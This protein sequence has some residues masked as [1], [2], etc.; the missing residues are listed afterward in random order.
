MKFNIPAGYV[1]ITKKDGTTIVCREEQAM[2]LLSNIPAEQ[3]KPAFEDSA[4]LRKALKNIEATDAVDFT[5][6]AL[7]NRPFLHVVISSYN[8]IL[9]EKYHVADPRA[10]TTEL[11]SKGVLYSRPAK[12]GALISLKP[13]TKPE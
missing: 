9:R 7:S 4:V 8:E 6:K 12:K 10:F 11:V 1:S 13:F 5:M 3:P 2:K